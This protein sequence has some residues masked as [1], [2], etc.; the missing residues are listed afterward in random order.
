MFML[1]LV[2]EP[3]WKTSIG[4]SSKWSPAMTASAAAVIASACSAAITPS[5]ALT[6]AVDF[7]TR[8]IATTCAGSRVA[9]LI[10]K[11][12]T[13]R[14]VW[15]RHRASAGTSMS[16]ML[17]CSVRVSPWWRGCSWLADDVTE[18]ARGRRERCRSLLAILQ[19]YAVALL[20]AVAEH[21]VHGLPQLRRRVRGPHHD[22]PATGSAAAWC[23][24]GSRARRAVHSRRGRGGRGRCRRRAARGRRSRWG[25]RDGHHDVGGDDVHPLVGEQCRAVRDRAVR[26]SSRSAHPRSRR[27]SLARLACRPG[28]AGW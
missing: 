28:R 1:E 14:S 21:A 17:S 15:A 9:P 12:S 8:A 6:R 11:F 2:P 20:G 5:W 19:E 26:A 4:N 16:P 18:F 10:G 13:T 22:G 25:L 7:F 27:P 3:V 24:P 23:S